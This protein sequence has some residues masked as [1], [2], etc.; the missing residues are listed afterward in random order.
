[1]TRNERNQKR[2]RWALRLSTVAVLTFDF[3][4]WSLKG[5]AGTTVSGSPSCVARADATAVDYQTGVV[6][7]PKGFSDVLGYEPV[8]VETP[9]GWRYVRP[10]AECSG[11]LADSGPFW[12][13]SNACGTHDYGY[14]LVRFGVGDRRATDSL[15]HDDMLRE[16][17]REGLGQAPCKALAE[18]AYAALRVGDGNGFDPEPIEPD[19]TQA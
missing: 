7:P 14:D 8:L 16:C 4:G 15:F 19:T 3:I 12:D 2:R 10:G 17:R 9:A 1:M 11:P 18:W 5:S 6:C 13:F